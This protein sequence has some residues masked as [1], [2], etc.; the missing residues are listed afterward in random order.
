MEELQASIESIRDCISVLQGDLHQPGTPAIVLK[1]AA[2]WQKLQPSLTH[3]LKTSSGDGELSQQETS[4]AGLECGPVSVDP[5]SGR[6]EEETG[7]SVCVADG[8]GDGSYAGGGAVKTGSKSS[9]TGGGAVTQVSAGS[10]DQQLAS[11]V[12]ETQ[13]SGLL[14]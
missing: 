5:P 12:V 9:S 4:T 13:S 10:D 14:N 6:A 11:E 7:S 3:F 2:S 8:V 1:L